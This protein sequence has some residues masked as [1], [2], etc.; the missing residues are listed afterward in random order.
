MFGRYKE[1][2]EIVKIHNDLTNEKLGKMTAKNLIYLCVFVI[3]CM[4]REIVK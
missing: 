1:L 4:I 2:N 3:K